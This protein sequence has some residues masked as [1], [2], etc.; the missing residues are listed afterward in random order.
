MIGA[1]VLLLK[2]KNRTN[3][4]PSQFRTADGL[5]NRNSAHGGDLP[6]RSSAQRAW[7]RRVGGRSSALYAENIMKIQI[8]WSKQWLVRLFYY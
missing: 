7:R 3:Q 8:P 5:V 4:V 2:K 1:I 6:N